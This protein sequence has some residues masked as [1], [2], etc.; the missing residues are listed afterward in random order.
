MQSILKQI[1]LA[2]LISVVPAS[3]CAQRIAPPAPTAADQ[4]SAPQAC[5]SRDPRRFPQDCRDS[6]KIGAGR[7]VP[8]PAVPP[9]VAV[10]LSEAAPPSRSTT[11]RS[12]ADEVRTRPAAP[13]ST[14]LAASQATQAGGQAGPTNRQIS[15]LIARGYFLE[16]PASE[17]EAGVISMRGQDQH[18]GHSVV[19]DADGSANV[20]ASVGANVYVETATFYV[21]DNPGPTCTRLSSASM[22]CRFQVHVK[23]EV[24]D[25]IQNVRQGVFDL[26]TNRQPS[27]CDG[28][29]A[30]FN[31]CGRP[32]QTWDHG[33][34]WQTVTAEF[35]RTGDGWTSTQLRRDMARVAQAATARREAVARE[36]ASAVSSFSQAVQRS[37]T[38]IGYALANATAM[39]PAE[40]NC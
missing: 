33:F 39:A 10:P 23:L 4:A 31:L 27:G 15:A 28:E 35:Q 7:E 38:C 14:A 5:G 13:S 25:L 36:H 17:R 37:N 19:W 1:A 26:L 32:V 29:F 40:L 3:V 11:A 2:S 12:Y 34:W 21:R 6:S 8:A 24:D 22:R 18:G 9:V 16:S 30:R 20:T